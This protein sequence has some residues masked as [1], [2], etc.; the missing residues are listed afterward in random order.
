MV[1]WHHRLDGREFEQ[2]PGDGEGQGG[3]E[4]CTPWGHKELAVTELLNNNDTRCNST[5]GFSISVA[6]L[7][8]MCLSTFLCF[9]HC[10]PCISPCSQT[11][12][13]FSILLLR[14]VPPLSPLTDSSAHKTMPPK[15]Q[16]PT[17]TEGNIK[18]LWPILLSEANFYNRSK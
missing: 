12:S 15:S 9:L 11:S 13:F 7:N 16:P 14:S 10:L 18:C 4:C 2:A 1:E 6:C 17:P 5:P 8:P 3:M